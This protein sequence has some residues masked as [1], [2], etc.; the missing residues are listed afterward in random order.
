MT[1]TEVSICNGGLLLVGA[2]DINSFSDNTTEAK[3]CNSIYTDTKKILLQYHPWRFSLAQIDLGG[4][5]V[6]EPL[7][8]WKYQYQLPADFLRVLYIKDDADYEIFGTKIYTD[9]TTCQIVYQSNVS[10]SVMP[11]YFIR[12]LQFHL[13]KIFSLSLQ[14]DL[15][16]MSMFDRAADKETARARSI[17]SQQQPNKAI[18]LVN[19][20]LL[21]VRG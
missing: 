7:F 17:D 1:A 20:T 14:E 4:A 19:Y 15:D 13:A 18:S 21:N 12:C 16:K 6:S 8:N 3:L 2:D 11:A 5:L 10:E 9:N